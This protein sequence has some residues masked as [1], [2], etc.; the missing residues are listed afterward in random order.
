MLLYLYVC[1]GVF[2]CLSERVYVC[3]CV[4][5]CASARVTMRECVCVCVCVHV[6]LDIIHYKYWQ[7]A[8][9]RSCCWFLVGLFIHF[10]YSCVHACWFACTSVCLSMPN[11]LRVWVGLGLFWRKALSDEILSSKITSQHGSSDNRHDIRVLSSPCC[12]LSI[13]HVRL[14]CVIRQLTDVSCHYN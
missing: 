1:V 7:T 11:W 8:S 6:L 3:L 4:C 12:L 5:V 2:V 13:V 10:T 9:F 14:L